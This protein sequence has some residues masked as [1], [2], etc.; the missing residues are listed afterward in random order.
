MSVSSTLCESCGAPTV[1]VIWRSTPIVTRGSP[2]IAQ[3]QIKLTDSLEDQW[4]V[5]SRIHGGSFLGASRLFSYLRCSA[6]TR[7]IF[8][9][10][11]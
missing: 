6:K 2:K 11:L 4:S 8:I 9:P 10:W 7:G 1:L 3:N 5:Y